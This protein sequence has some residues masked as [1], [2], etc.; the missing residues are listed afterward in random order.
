MS[1][2]SCKCKKTKQRDKEEYTKLI[3]RLNRIEGQIR[4]I[5]NM[6]ENSA[7]CTDILTQSSAVSFAIKAFN[8]ELLSNHLHTCVVHDIQEGKIETID[9]LANIV[10]K[11]IK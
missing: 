5:R 11:L 9:E 3:H 8:A 7:H 6:V 2:K 10:Q 1:E 4:G